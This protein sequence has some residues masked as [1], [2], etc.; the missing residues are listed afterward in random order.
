MRWQDVRKSLKTNPIGE[1]RIEGP[2]PMHAERYWLKSFERSVPGLDVAALVTML[3]GSRVR[4]DEA[5][6]ARANVL[7]GQSL[8]VPAACATRWRY[9]GAV[10]FVVFYLTER[11]HGIQQRICA[12]A[13]SCGKPCLFGDALVSASA[14][15]IVNEL[16]RGAH[17]DKRY[18]TMLARVML[19]QTVRV[20]GMP[21]VRGIQTRHVHFARLQAVLT[22]IHDHLGEDLSATVLSRHAGVSEAHF[23]RIFEQAAG[24]SP[25][26]YVLTARLE[27][28]RKLLVTGSTPISRIAQ[29]CGFSSQSHLTERFRGAYAA[30]P[31]QY[32]DHVTRKRR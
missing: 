31:A 24:T 11:M 3:G 27:Q 12:L 29:E 22:F 23:R 17:M 30:T 5:G 4:E 6:R 2:V 28:A 8:L 16:Q 9:T 19:E 13:D 15:Q 18:T 10:D 20:L 7:P 1:G 25:H 26:R 14:Q 21:P 32:R